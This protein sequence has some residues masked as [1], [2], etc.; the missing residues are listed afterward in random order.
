[1]IPPNGLLRI[2]TRTT[3]VA[4]AQARHVQ[5]LVVKTAPDIVTQIVG[6]DVPIDRRDGGFASSGGKDGFLREIDRRLLEGRVDIAVHSM[7]DVPGDVPLPEG[8]TFGAYLPRED[9]RDA[10]VFRSGSPWRSLADVPQGTTVGASSV[11][12]AAQLLRLRPDLRV[13]QIQG[14]VAAR[15]DRLD[16]QDHYAALVLARSGLERLGAGDRIREVLSHDVM[17]PPVGAGVTGLQCRVDDTTV[18]DLL[19]Q[20]DDAVTRTHVT[21]ERMLLHNLRGHGGSPI[22]A[23]CHT[24]PDGRLAL[25]GMVFTRDGRHVVEAS[26][27]DDPDRPARLGTTVATELLRKGAR[28]LIDAAPR[29]GG[30]PRPWPGPARDRAL[31]HRV[32][33]R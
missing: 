11:R 31:R 22:A 15:L 33:W 27:R 16:E 28:A 32:G 1:M 21:A 19:Y 5:D 10:V 6:V 30:L 17:C 20:I 24:T 4:L 2:G 3:P 23:H 25:R 8:T 14:D 13:E 7:K 18:V 12:R 9:V 29:L 26:G